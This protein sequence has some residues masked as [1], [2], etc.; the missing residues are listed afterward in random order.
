MAEQ[1]GLELIFQEVF[2]GLGG[3]DAGIPVMGKNETNETVLRGI[4]ACLIFCIL[5]CIKH[6]L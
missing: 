5:S 6:F 1:Y 2:R 4:L 3:A